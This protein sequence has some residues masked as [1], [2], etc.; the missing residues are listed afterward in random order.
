MTMKINLFHELGPAVVDFLTTDERKMLD[1]LSVRL[2]N[3]PAFEQRL[4]NDF[5]KGH[6]DRTEAAQNDSQEYKSNIQNSF[7]K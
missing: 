7:A 5:I 4:K 6:I 2:S 1:A 3:D